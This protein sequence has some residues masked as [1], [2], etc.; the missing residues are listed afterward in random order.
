MNRRALL[1]FLGLAP[2]GLPMLAAAGS[3][4]FVGDVAT[5]P[6]QVSVDIGPTM[7]QMAASHRDCIQM[8]RPIVFSEDDLWMKDC[9]DP[10]IR[11]GG[12]Q[13]EIFDDRAGDWS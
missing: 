11:P 8:S 5:L 4:G 13:I 10:D 9:P 1:R 12:D 7:E 2:A 3:S 6:M